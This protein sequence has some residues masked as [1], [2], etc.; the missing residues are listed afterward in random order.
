MNVLGVRVVVI[1]VV[2]IL[3]KD[4]YVMCHMLSQQMKWGKQQIALLG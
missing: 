4:E 3:R 2:I 1:V